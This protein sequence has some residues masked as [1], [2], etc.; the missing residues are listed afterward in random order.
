MAVI[1]QFLTNGVIFSGMMIMPV[2]LIRGC[3]FTESQ[4]GWL[5]LPLGLGMISVN[6]L[7]GMLVQRFG[8]RKVSIAGAL[9]SLMG[10]LPFIY[11]ASTYHFSATS[12]MPKFAT[13]FEN[14][15]CTK[16]TI[17][18]LLAHSG[19]VTRLPMVEI[20]LLWHE[21][22]TTAKNCRNKKYYS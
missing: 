16:D 6:P 10:T 11:M 5:L 2:F 8:T 15:V 17:N 18:L 14:L 13:A 19:H 20:C 7:M 12:L 9:V 22:S 21:L 1:T 4:M 3:S